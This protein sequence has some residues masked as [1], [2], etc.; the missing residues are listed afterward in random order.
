VLEIP[1]DVL[2]GP[3]DRMGALP[4]R[5]KHAAV[6]ARSLDEAASLLSRAKRPVIVAGR[7]IVAAGAE[8]AL[9]QLAEKLQAPVFADR[10]A[11][12]ALP[13]DHPLA[14]GF[15]WSP[16]TIGEDLMREADVV[17][18]IGP[19]EQA[20]TGAR[21]P[22]QIGQQL[23][24]LDWD[25]ASQDNGAPARLKLAGHVGD[26]LADLVELIKDR[27]E[28]AFPQETLDAIR[29]GPWRYAEGRVPWA[30]DFFRSLEDALPRDV[31][32]FT[33]SLVGLWIF[34]LLK[35]YEGRSYRFGW[36]N[37]SGTLGY[38]FPG[39][40]GAKLAEPHREVVCIAGD[41]AALY[42]PQELATMRLYGMKVTY[43]VANDNCFGAVRDNLLDGY[44]ATIGHELVNPDFVKLAEA[45]GMRGI[46]TETPAG[47]G[48]ALR[49]ALAG[50]RSTLIEV[51]LELRPGRY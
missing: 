22:E 6:D 33:D 11:K 31:L 30:L 29:E 38:G 16:T 37:G 17:L 1:K 24:H 48:D 51:P 3:A 26:A 4:T 12:G 13:E 47:I 39:G 43:I 8:A 10:N 19:R 34:R 46:K 18:A 45:F 25:A 32:F 9:L 21:S 50:D 35:A 28:S 42:N 41:G 27:Q 44:G 14:L 15:T 49:E 23:I 7:P 5:P 2:V 36:G 40:I 20:A